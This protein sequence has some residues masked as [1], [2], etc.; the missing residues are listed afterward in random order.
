MFYGEL[1]K[2]YDTTIKAITV[3]Q[4]FSTYSSQ[5]EMYYA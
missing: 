1:Q 5:K 2:K 3:D 4:H